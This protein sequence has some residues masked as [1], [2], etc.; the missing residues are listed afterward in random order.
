MFHTTNEETMSEDKTR[1]GRFPILVLLAGTAQAGM[2]P[3][4]IWSQA[5]PCDH[6]LSTNFSNPCKASR[7]IVRTF[8]PT[9]LCSG[10]KANLSDVDFST[11]TR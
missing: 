2:S 8:C 7:A 6:R 10:A 3:S 11:Q 4:Q 5:Y 9:V 1:L